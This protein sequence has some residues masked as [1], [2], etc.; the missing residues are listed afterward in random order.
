MLLE[1]S[2]GAS[3]PIRLFVFFFGFGREPLV[4]LLFS[5]LCW[6]LF[7]GNPFFDSLFLGR[8][9]LLEREVS[10]TPTVI[11][12]ARVSDFSFHTCRFELPRT[13]A[14]LVSDTSFV[15]FPIKLHTRFLWPRREKD[16]TNQVSSSNL[17]GANCQLRV[18]WQTNRPPN[19]T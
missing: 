4:G 5:R 18:S 15:L 8:L 1:P 12:L 3:R 16:Q 9:F 6:R 2:L 17:P 13:G 10:R 7:G 11:S 19:G 14:I